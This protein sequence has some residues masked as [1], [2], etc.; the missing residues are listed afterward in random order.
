M[1]ALIAQAAHGL[2]AVGRGRCSPSGWITCC[3][4][5]PESQGR[6]HP[7]SPICRLQG[8][9]GR[10]GASVPPGS[11]PPA[12]QQQQLAAPQPGAEPEIVV[13]AEDIGNVAAWRQEWLQELE[14][15]SASILHGTKVRPSSCCISC[16]VGPIGPGQGELQG[17]QALRVSASARRGA[18][19]VEKRRHPD[20]R[21]ASGDRL[22][23]ALSCRRWRHCQ[24]SPAPAVDAH[25]T[26]R[27]RGI[28]GAHSPALKQLAQH[29]QDSVLKQNICESAGMRRCH[30]AARHHD[31]LQLCRAA[32]GVS[33]NSMLTTADCAYSTPSYPAMCRCLSL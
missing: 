19:A 3:S 10:N 11:L 31:R 1:A 28:A 4:S 23:S 20:G 21:G 7:C 18:N 16:L 12:P 32:K 25:V 8:F 33:S 29:M 24:I 5:R 15:P 14:R 6:S 27:R 2:R 9:P 17:F 13:M 26:Q 30:S 22:L